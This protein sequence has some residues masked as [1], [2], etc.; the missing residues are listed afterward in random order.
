MFGLSVIAAS[1]G[2]LSLT[3]VVETKNTADTDAAASSVGSIVALAVGLCR[4]GTLTGMKE[5]VRYK[6]AVGSDPFT[7]TEWVHL[8]MLDPA[9][10]FN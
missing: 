3:V 8:Q 7:G 1:S 9:W 5:L 10:L 2:A 6:Y 4:T